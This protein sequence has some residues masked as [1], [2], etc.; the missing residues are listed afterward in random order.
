MT[1]TEYYNDLDDADYATNYVERYFEECQELEPDVYINGDGEVIRDLHSCE[2]SGDEV[3]NFYDIIDDPDEL[4]EI[5]TTLAAVLK[6]G[7]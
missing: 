2:V 4:T 3:I 7:K 6:E 1:E 5:I